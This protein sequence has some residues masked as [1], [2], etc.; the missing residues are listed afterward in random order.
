MRLPSAPRLVPACIVSAAAVA[1]LAAPGAANA[2]LGTQCSGSN[3]TAQGSSLQKDAQ[4]NVWNP[5]F[6]TETKS[7]AACA[8]AKGQGTLGKP[9]VK[10][11]STGSGAGL[12]AW[13]VNKQTPN[14][15]TNAF[16]GTDEPPNA[17]QIA[18]IEANETTLVPN[19]VLSIPVVQESVAV[20]VNLPTGCTATS[21]KDAGRLELNNKTLEGI[22]K[23]DIKEWGEIKDDGDTIT[24]TGCATAAIQPVVRFDQSGT[25]HIFK[26]YLSLINEGSFATEK[27]ENKTWTQISEGTE[28]TVWPKAAK[29]IKPAAKGGGEEL[30]KVASTPGSIGYANIAEARLNG[31]FTPTPGTGGPGTAKFWAT[32]QNNGLAT[33]TESKKFKYADPSSNGDSATEAEANCKDTEFTNGS[34][35]FPPENTQLPWN[36]VTTSTIEKKYP[37]CGL[38][39]DLAFTSFSAYSGTSLGEATTVNNYLQWELN[40][41]GGGGQ[42]VIAGHDYLALPK[43]VILEEAQHGASIIGD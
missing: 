17:A 39:Y 3:I 4:L 11:T 16:V 41:K 31:S 27:E 14:Y 21:K 5:D 35:A 2:A 7:K 28:N 1:A 34:V 26:K 40:A 38:T 9:A 13:G 25:T 10:Y 20:V 15:T 22:F 32:I 30:A 37:L 23:G 42:K 43:G 24:G 29:V 6:N 8:G 19:T 18:E 36:E 12:E 33:G